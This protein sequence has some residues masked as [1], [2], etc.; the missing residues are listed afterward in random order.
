[1]RTEGWIFFFFFLVQLC[2]LWM[3]NCDLPSVLVRRPREA[4]RPCRLWG[5]LFPRVLPH[6]REALRRCWHSLELGKE[7]LN[8]FCILGGCLGH[9]LP[10]WR[11]REGSDAAWSNPSS[12]FTRGYQRVCMFDVG[13]KNRPG[14]SVFMDLVCRQYVFIG[15]VQ[16]R[17]LLWSQGGP[18]HS[19]TSPARPSKRSGLQLRV[20]QMQRLWAIFSGHLQGTSF[21]PLVRAVSGLEDQQYTLT[22]PNSF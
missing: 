15:R 21:L 11:K 8:N 17:M 5:L 6:C 22:W 9:F 3:H 1:M 16:P 18:P 7:R 10:R 20:G 13:V 2:L 12:T 19:S 14:S 4:R